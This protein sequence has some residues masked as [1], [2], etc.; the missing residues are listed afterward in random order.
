VIE[1]LNQ[2]AR[3]SRRVLRDPRPQVLFLGFG[4]SSLSFE[5]RAFVRNAEQLFP[6][7]HDLHMAIDKAFREAGIEIAFPQ[8]D[9]H[10]RSMPDEWRRPPRSPE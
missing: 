3:E 8:R 6:V 7:R 10:L 1:V 9:L 4:D 5:L 2:V